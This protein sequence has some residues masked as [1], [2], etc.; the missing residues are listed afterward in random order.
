MT[1]PPSS[2]TQIED[3]CAKIRLFSE[4]STPARRALARLAWAVTHTDGEVIIL[5]QDS[6]APVYFIVAGTVRVFR[7]NL[8]GREQTLVYLKAGEAFNVPTAFARHGFPIQT[9][10]TPAGAPASASSVGETTLLAVAARDFRRVVSETPEIALA[11]LGDLADKL[12]Y[13]TTM[14]YDLSLRSV[15]ERL[16]QFLLRQATAETKE[17]SHWTQEEIAMQIGT[18][19]E[20]VSR[21]LRAFVKEGMIGMRRQRIEILDQRALEAEAKAWD[22]D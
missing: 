1:E 18:V 13:M 12:R 5:A 19:R 15:R 8:D 22:T 20:V 17:T 21:T 10:P 4:L 7:T 3:L 2:T 6:N 9:S 16:A 14:V 11:V